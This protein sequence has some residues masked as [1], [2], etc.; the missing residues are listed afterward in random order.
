MQM[1]TWTMQQLYSCRYVNELFPSS[2]W[3][4]IVSQ[5]P[6]LT[7]SSAQQLSLNLTVHSWQT[8]LPLTSL[9]VA[10]TQYKSLSN[11][12]PLNF[13]DTWHSKFKVQSSCHVGPPGRWHIQGEEL[14][15]NWWQ[16]KLKRAQLRVKKLFKS[17]KHGCEKEESMVVKESIRVF[18]ELSLFVCSMI[19]CSAKVAWLNSGMS[20]SGHSLA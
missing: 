2:L 13:A 19:K 3:Y 4:L 17:T 7:I 12:S 18:Q 15:R 6:C 14:N 5:H 8:S 11:I 16:A 9:H 20:H 1:Q 10:L